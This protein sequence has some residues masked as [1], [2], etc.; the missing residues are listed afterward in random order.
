MYSVS[1]KNWA[2]IA[3]PISRPLAFEADSVRSLKIRSGSR[4]AFE[5]ISTATNAPSSAAEI[6]S[7]AIDS[8][9]PQPCWAARVIA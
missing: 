3:P 7:S 1:R 6:A 5:R 9:V 4:G 8:V 2:K